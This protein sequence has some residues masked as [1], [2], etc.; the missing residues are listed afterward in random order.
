MAST[1]HVCI[2]GAETVPY[3]VFGDANRAA[4]A[5]C[6]AATVPAVALVLTADGRECGRYES[7]GEGRVWAGY[8]WHPERDHP[9]RSY[10]PDRYQPHAK[11]GWVVHRVERLADAVYK[12]RA[13]GFNLYTGERFDW[14]LPDLSGDFDLTAVDDAL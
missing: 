5:H 8:G 1:Y 13:A 6:K 9:G 4:M 10:H 11:L 7:D 3:P 12:F 2:S 14:R